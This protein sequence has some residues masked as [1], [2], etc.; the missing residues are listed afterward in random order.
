MHIIFFI[1]PYLIVL[2]R[3]F[4]DEF[5]LFGEGETLRKSQETSGW[6]RNHIFK[7]KC[8]SFEITSFDHWK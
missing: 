5:S 8:N 1:K 6:T 2:V 4:M 3:I 7:S